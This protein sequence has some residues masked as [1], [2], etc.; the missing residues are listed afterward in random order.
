[1]SWRTCCLSMLPVNG[2]LRGVLN[3]PQLCLCFGHLTRDVVLDHRDVTERAIIGFRPDDVPGV[4][5][6]QACRNPQSGARFANASVEHICHAE[7]LCDLSY[8]NLLT[9]VKE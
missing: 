6:N 9:L 4:S 3:W 1:V 2:R 7:S 5:A 8:R